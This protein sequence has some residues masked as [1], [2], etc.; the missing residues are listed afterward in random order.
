MNTTC[1]KSSNKASGVNEEI[2]TRAQ[3]RERLRR[4]GW[5]IRDA[6]DAVGLKAHM[7]LHRILTGEYQNQRVLREI[8]RLG[9]SPRRPYE[10]RK[11][12]KGGK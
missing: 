6:A 7:S 10:R 1:V 9:P 8:G 3:A 5:T 2:L 12:C 11:K 4:L